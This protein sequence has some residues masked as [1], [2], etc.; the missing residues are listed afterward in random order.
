MNE[1]KLNNEL[2]FSVLCERQNKS[3]F[4]AKVS[5]NNTV[6]LCKG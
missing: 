2:H 4:A 1:I 5:S 6:Y 3:V